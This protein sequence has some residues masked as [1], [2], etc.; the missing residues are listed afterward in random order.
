LAFTILAYFLDVKILGFGSTRD[1]TKNPRS[2]PR[3]IIK[4]PFL[5]GLAP[6]GQK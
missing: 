6:K 4:M 5:P 1:N 2:P 3:K